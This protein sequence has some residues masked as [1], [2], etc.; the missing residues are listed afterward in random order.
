MHFVGLS[1]NLLLLMSG[2]RMSKYMHSK[3][4][5]FDYKFFVINSLQPFLHAALHNYVIPQGSPVG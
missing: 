2:D 1:I 5:S 3:Y 4:H